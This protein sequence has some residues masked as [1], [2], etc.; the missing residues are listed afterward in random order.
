MKKKTK[1][2][3]VHCGHIF[4]LQIMV[5]SFHGNICSPLHSDCSA[6]LEAVQYVEA[7][8][9]LEE[10][11]PLEAC[12]EMCSSILLPALFLLPALLWCKKQGVQ[13][14]KMELFSNDCFLAEKKS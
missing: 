11:K 7:E 4:N 5:Y 3:E 8:A 10:V 1:I 2:Y 9:S 13:S 12:C 14:S 6:V